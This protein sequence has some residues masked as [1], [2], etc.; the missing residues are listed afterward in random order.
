MLFPSSFW[1]S[2]WERRQPDSLS[3]EY[4]GFTSCKAPFQDSIMSL[5]LVRFRPICDKY[6]INVS[7]R[8]NDIH[9]AINLD[10][11]HW[12]ERKTD[13]TAEKNRSHNRAR[14]SHFSY[15]TGSA[16]APTWSC[17]SES[18]AGASRDFEIPHI[19]ARDHGGWK[20]RMK[21]SRYDTLQIVNHAGIQNTDLKSLPM[22]FKLV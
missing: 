9:G 8:L 6:S 7:S 11:L 1:S 12:R 22:Y 21:A 5:L 13:Q 20:R 10:H 17:S 4:Q 2:R 19:Y 18:V 3:C 14:Q 15:R 16:A